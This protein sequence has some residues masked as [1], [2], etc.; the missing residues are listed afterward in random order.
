MSPLHPFQCYQV[1]TTSTPH[2]IVSVSPHSDL[3]HRW[4]NPL[5]HASARPCHNPP[6]LTSCFEAF[7]SLSWC[8]SHPTTA[9]SA[10]LS[11]L[12]N[13][14]CS[15]FSGSNVFPDHPPTSLHPL[16]AVPLPGVWPNTRHPESSRQLYC[17]DPKSHLPG[18]HISTD[19]Q[20]KSSLQE[21]RG[22]SEVQH[23]HLQR[24]QRHQG[25][26]EQQR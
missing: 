25:Q 20:E 26:R 10:L 14:C 7:C 13:Q 24:P 21:K 12:D 2:H 15:P 19:H 23:G 16:L 22:N 18:H 9:F 11:N 4:S 3:L 6:H 5:L 1:K 8:L 17:L